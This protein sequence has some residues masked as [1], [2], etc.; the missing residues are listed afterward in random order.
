[1]IGFSGRRNLGLKNQNQRLPRNILVKVDLEE[2][3]AYEGNWFSTKISVVEFE[4]KQLTTKY[5]N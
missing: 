5:Q 2:S 1:M 4:I 3:N